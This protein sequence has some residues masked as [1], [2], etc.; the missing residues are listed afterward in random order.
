[1]V[2]IVVTPGYRETMV[3]SSVLRVPGFAF[4]SR[5]AG[6]RRFAPQVP[7]SKFQVQSSGFRPGFKY[8]NVHKLAKSDRNQ[9]R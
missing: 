6:F 5:F 9:L 1:M 4:R 3:S 8:L 7:G 2:E